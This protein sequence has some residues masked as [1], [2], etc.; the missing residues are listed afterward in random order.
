MRNL[1]P[2]WEKMTDDAYL[3]SILGHDQLGEVKHYNQAEVRNEP[4]E[5]WLK[6][7]EPQPEQSENEDESKEVVKPNRRAM[8]GFADMSDAIKNY[9]EST[10]Q[11]SSRKVKIDKVREFHFTLSKWV[12]E[13]PK[14]QITQTVVTK[15]KGNTASAGTGTVDLKAN[16]YTFQAWEIVVGKDRLTEFNN[17]KD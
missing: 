8:K 1:S 13:N 5:N 17:G 16:R 14:L 2:E 3:R 10:V 6:V 12:A 7:P 4:S 9:T 11:T 15:N